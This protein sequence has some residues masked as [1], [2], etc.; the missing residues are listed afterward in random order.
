MMKKAM[1]TLLMAAIIPAISAT[2]SE[3]DFLGWTSAVIQC[4][5]TSKAGEISC[6]I[7]TGE[8]GWEKFVIRAFGNTYT[9]PATDLGKLTGF[10]LSSL[11]TTHEGG[12]EELG[13]YTVHFRFHRTFYNPEKKLVSETINVSVTKNGVT[14]SDRRTKEHRG[15]QSPTLPGEVEYNFP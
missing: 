12:Y 9:L 15:Q 3:E 6:E 8:N 4:G 5:K 2:S 11:K 10:P 1:I 14:V 13:G 7:K